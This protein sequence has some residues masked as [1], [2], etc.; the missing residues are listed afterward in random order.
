MILALVQLFNVMHMKKDGKK[1]AKNAPFEKIDYTFPICNLLLK[2]FKP[3]LKLN[4]KPVKLF[5]PTNQI[6]SIT[7][8]H[9][10]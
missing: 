2:S 7:L 10:T 4:H 8:H 5:H 3:Y 6:Y 1:V 9:L